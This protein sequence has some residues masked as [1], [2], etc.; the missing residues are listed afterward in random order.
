MNVETSKELLAVLENLSLFEVTFQ[1]RQE[2]QTVT[3]AHDDFNVGIVVRQASESSSM[4]I[5]HSCIANH[6]L[7]CLDNYLSVISS[8]CNLIS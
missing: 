2:S 7:Q 3:S 4:I 6:K 5:K 1:L 8:L